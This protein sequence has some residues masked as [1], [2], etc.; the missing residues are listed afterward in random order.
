MFLR[1]LT[2]QHFRNYSSLDILF[3]PGLIL[4]QGD[5]AQGKTNLLE[6]I[7][8]L[9]TTKSSR[10]R[11]DADLVS[12]TDRDPLAGQA[13]ARIVGRIERGHNRQVLEIVIREGGADGAARKRFKLNGTER[14]AGDVL[15]KVNAVFFSPADVDLVAGGPSLRRRF[16]DVMLCQVNPPYL[17]SLNR[18]NRAILQR[19]ALLRQVRDRAQPAGGLEFW[20][21][22]VAELGAQIVSWRASAIRDLAAR[23]PSGSQGSRKASSISSFATSP[24]LQDSQTDDLAGSDDS[25]AAL[26]QLKRGIARVKAREIAAGVS[27]VG[28]HRDDSRLP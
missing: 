17:R 10:A 24:A 11:T 5:N 22:H 19:N 13:F 27:L 21:E 26:V 14:R 1:Q 25:L 16:L 9:A 15:G 8:M 6:A 23:Q 28:P 4:L 7:Y 18:Y 20:D 2:L 3:E 12:W